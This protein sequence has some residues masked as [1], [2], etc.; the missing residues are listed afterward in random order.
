M[1]GSIISHY[2]VLEKLG[3]GGMGLVYRAKDLR[4]GRMVALKALPEED[5]LDPAR[6]ARFLLEAK[7][8]SALN[9]PNII[10]VYEIETVG[11]VDY[12]AMELVQ[13]D[14]LLHRIGPA[15]LSLS[16]AL[17]YATQIASGLAA[18]HAA[19]IVHRDIKPANIMV[20]KTG[21]VKILDFGLARI[22]PQHRGAS[23]TTVTISPEA[24]SYP[25][26][27][28]GTLA[29]MSPEQIQGKELD[30]R[31]DIFSFGVVLFQM[32]TGRPPFESNSDVG[33]MYEIVHGSPPSLAGEGRDIAPEL[34]RILSTAL[35]K[36]LDR[37]Y[38]TS[39]NLAEDLK[40]FTRQ[41]E[42][43]VASASSSPPP[44]E[45]AVK[46]VQ[47]RWLPAAAAVLVIL[48]VLA[49]LG[50]KFAPALF[51]TVFNNVPAEK[52]IAVLPF[53]NVGAASEN[54]ALC[55]GIM[56]AL[57]SELTQLEQF[58]GSLWV[59]PSTE[60]RREQLSSAAGARRTLGANLVISGSLQ[61]DSRQVILTASLVDTGTLRQL[62]SRTIRKP[63]AEFADL[64]E[65]VV[66]EIARM[67]ELELGNQERQILAAG[68]TKAAGA[69]DFYLQAQGYLQRRN[70]AD[71]DRAIDLFERAVAQDSNYVLAYAGLGEA[72]WKKYRAT[73][74][75]QWV[76]PAE[77]NCN[78]AL[79]LSDR[80]AP[81]YVTLGI[82]QE[83]TGHYEDAIRTFQRA[84]ELDPINAS[85]YSELGN[86]YLAAG[87]LEESESTYKKA[88]QL[89]PNDF[90]SMLNL[91]V[92]Y[93]DRGR[94]QDAA[95]IFQRMTELVPD[96]SSGYTNL[97]SV[98]WMNG[99]Y[100]NAAISYE[101]S[102]ALR[103]TASAYSSL[104]TVYFFQDRC[105]EAVPLMEKAS[106]I[107]PK[108]D[109][110]WGNLG[111]VYGC[112]PNGRE[113]AV[114]AYRRAVQLGE[115]RLMVNPNDAET[116]GRVAL[117][118]AR[119]GD[120]G[121]AVV[122]T[123]RA[124]QLAPTSRSVAWHAALTYELAGQR[125]LALA[126]VR[127]ALRAG[128][129]V[130]EVSHEPTLAMLRSDPRYAQLMAEH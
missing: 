66:R 1:I 24:Y 16:E 110:V 86:A 129:P 127:A 29:Y 33:L 94:Y 55:D 49:V 116:L 65:T 23:A 68:V 119:L 7:A 31:S 111:D 85:A 74:D 112:S 69:Y 71:L 10:T 76:E 82:V 5:N 109:Q 47:R 34:A 83:G 96:N 64:Q 100:A 35:E 122:K 90:T 18:A 6:K 91:G 72:Y 61:R 120:H 22:Q 46:R 52:K 105:P 118:R 39:Q 28:V 113:K 54:Q 21:L 60:V 56:E 20:T 126:S 45:P 80:L 121:D 58:H 48:A 77:K 50:W 93:Y 27:V 79:A 63:F 102:L 78:R 130:Q 30:Q 81:V 92:F 84:L 59:V 2:E 17:D 98:Y 89:R 32:L 107:L 51:N 108:S 26:I 19:G 70:V 42:S 3:E 75:T 101:K 44:S 40:Q 114:Q 73:S 95:G 36:D 53:L 128:Q 117:Y 9:H 41:L 106:E 37:R 67:L 13:G 115:E 57:T 87:K 43:G 11:G 8:A 12:I 99:Q 15:G 104:G 123:R 4:L 62:S 97:G 38:Q 124:L 88:S 14:T 25:G 125:E 103:P